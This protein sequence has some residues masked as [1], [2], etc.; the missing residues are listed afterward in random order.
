MEE[1]K[2]WLG[3]YIGEALGVFFIVL[4]GCGI[5]TVAVMVG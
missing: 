5:V 1:K 3:N 4:F 2:S